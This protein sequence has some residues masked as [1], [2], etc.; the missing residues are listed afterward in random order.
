MVEILNP[1]SFEQTL[2]ESLQQYRLLF[3]SS[4]LPIWVYDT[5]TLA[6]L[7]VN[8]AAVDHYGFSRDEFLAMT[9]KDIRPP[10]EVPG[11]LEDES[12]HPGHRTG[13]VWRHWK[14]DRSDI[15]VEVATHELV[16]SGRQARIVLVNDITKRKRA[17]DA[18]R[19]SHQ[20]NWEIVS[21]AGEGIIVCD[22]DLRCV[23]WNRFMEELT[24]LPS[25]D[26]LGKCTL[27]LFPQLGEQGIDD[28]L[29]RALDGE[30]VSSAEVA[31]GVPQSGKSGWAS[32]TYGPH[33]NAEGR[34]VGVIAV[35]RDITERRRAEEATKRSISLLQS[36]LDSTA[37]GILVVDEG[38]KI[39]SFN[40]R[41]VEM[42]RIP[43]DVL[44]S[45]DDRKALDWVLHQLKDPEQFLKKVLELYANRDAESF[46]VLEFEDGRV[47]ERYSIPQRLDGKAVGR[48]WSFRDVTE[49]KRA[50]EAL[51]YRV[52][53]EMLVTSISTRFIHMPLDEVDRGI[54]EALKAV[55]EFAGVDC[56]YVVLFSKD[57]SLGRTSHFWLSEKLSKPVNPPGALEL[58]RFSWS[59]D[60][61]RKLEPVHIPCVNDLPAEARPE[62]A[63]LTSLKV[64]SLLALPIVFAGRPRGILGFSTVR[65]DKSWPDDAVTLLRIVGEIFANALERRRAEKQLKHQAFHDSLTGLPNRSLLK[66]RLMLAIAQSRRKR[67]GLAVLFM[68]L[69]HF[70][71]VNDTLG[72]NFG[73][74][75][76]QAAAE[77]L[78]RCVREV[79]TLARVGG[80]EFILLL[81]DIGHGR[82]A[83]RV[84]EKI[85]DAMSKPFDLDG[86]LLYVTTSIGLS[87][88]PA[89]GRDPEILLQNA[90]NAMYRAKD[91][92]RNGYQLFT[93]AMNARVR[94]RLALE[95]GLRRALEKN[96]LI[97]N[98][99]PL[100]SF[101][102]G[103]IVGA[104]ALVRW[105]H[106][107]LGLMKPEEFIPVAE[108]TRLILPIGEWV[109]R[110]A[111]RQVKR[112]H[113]QGF[114]TLRLAV[115]L[116]AL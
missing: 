67:T 6:F 85:L 42:W 116:S 112:W 32:A 61:L 84:A 62:K 17:E 13:K 95:Q 63:L 105:R 103:Q 59:M 81:P 15:F 31:Y 65:E 99:Q 80:D 74:R 53:F 114:P 97:L 87:L 52:G 77:R 30:T 113:E 108:D 38:G 76:L 92:G 14:K 9:V 29:R 41:F 54:S 68:D 55:G 94:E 33:R 96:E 36:T 100:V 7:A 3:E 72:H 43:R 110:T 48:V 21:S 47:F 25:G 70:K 45:R 39:V 104:E 51:R 79:D 90:D 98:Y 115:N 89:D 71:L 5:R 88:Y 58:G 27:D 82:D 37:E 40:Q 8:Q 28:L 86:H 75:L 20:F 22:R 101:G 106:P 56:C 34:I 83:A 44:D 19:E 35:V 16:Y 102:T 111:C 24:G 109:L 64:R 50:E 66:D 1:A 93:P 46:E 69:D 57:R 10:E 49:R 91:L 23:V 60:R 12:K 2:N 4:P 73:D 107:E 11:L 78:I 26:V 18:L